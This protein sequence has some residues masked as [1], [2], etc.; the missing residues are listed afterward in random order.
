MCPIVH[1]AMSISQRDAES[2]V[3]RRV[4]LPDSVTVLPTR[5]AGTAPFPPPDGRGRK[6]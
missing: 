2:L 5:R 4:L 3:T 6:G 1:T